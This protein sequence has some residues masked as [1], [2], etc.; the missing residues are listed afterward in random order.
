MTSGSASCAEAGG[1]RRTSSGAGRAGAE[2]A[3]ACSGGSSLSS[4]FLPVPRY[5]YRSISSGTSSST[6]EKRKVRRPEKEGLGEG[7][8]ELPSFLG[9]HPS[10][11]NFRICTMS[12]S[13]N[14]AS[15][16]FLRV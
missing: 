15:L 9:V 3:G 13:G 8:R 7:G 11:K 2:A 4:G 12:T 10:K 5:E 16:V 14:E 1:D 6:S